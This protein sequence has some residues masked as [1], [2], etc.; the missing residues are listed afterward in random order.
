MHP[1]SAGLYVFVN[2]RGEYGYTELVG[3]Y[4]ME[5]SGRGIPL[6]SIGCGQNSGG[7]L[8]ARFMA[9]VL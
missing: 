3:M 4:G 1:K 2:G 5:F 8:R 6:G 7:A 9:S